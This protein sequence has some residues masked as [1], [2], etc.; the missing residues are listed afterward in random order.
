MRYQRSNPRSEG[1][2]E[3]KKR[4]E[5]RNETKYPT[6]GNPSKIPIH[7]KSKKESNQI[8]SRDMAKLG[9]GSVGIP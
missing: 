6:P 1:T 7:H 9:L 8:V 5:T 2:K 4:D 3:T